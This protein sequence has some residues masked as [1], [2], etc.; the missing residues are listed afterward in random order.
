MFGDNFSNT[1]EFF[2]GVQHTGRVAWRGEHDEFCARSYC[3]LKLFGGNF[4]IILK[5][6]FEKYA[7]AFGEAYKLFVT[8]PIRGGNDDLVA[9]VDE[10]LHNLI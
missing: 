4:E 1:F 6:C 7:F 9:W 3:S 8:N 10:T 5:F 2:F